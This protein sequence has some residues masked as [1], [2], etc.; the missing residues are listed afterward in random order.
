MLT[1]GTERPIRRPHA[2]K[3]Q[4]TTSSGKKK[5]QT[6]KDVTLTHPRTQSLLASTEE[7][8]GSTHDKNIVDEAHVRCATA[9]PLLGDRGFQGLELGQAVVTTPFTRTCKKKGEPNDELTEAQKEFNHEWSPQRLSIE[10]S[11]AGITRSRSVSEMLCHTRQGRSDHL[12]MV[13]MGLQN[14]R[15]STR[16]S[17]QF[18][19]LDD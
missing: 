4:N 16:A 18:S 10:Q 17:S 5:R 15:V 3:E 8:P 2:E 1:D 12:M 19:P 13:A 6:K 11:N 9:I 14:V 7:A